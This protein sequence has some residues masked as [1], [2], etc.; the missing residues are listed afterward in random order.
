MADP[1]F[2]LYSDAA[3]TSEITLLTFTTIP[4][5]TVNQDK[6]FFIGSTAV[7]KKLVNVNDLANQIVITFE[8]TNIG[9]GVAATDFVL[10]NSQLGL[11]GSLVQSL[12]IGTE[13]LSGVANAIEIFVRFTPPF[14]FEGIDTDLRLSMPDLFEVSQ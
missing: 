9:N 10:A 6:S 7:S 3:L 1:T 2:K 14:A 8:D 12:N 11:D 4:A 5:V 13:L